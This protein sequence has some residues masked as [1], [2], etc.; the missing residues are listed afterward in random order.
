MYSKALEASLQRAVAQYLDLK[1]YLWAH[2]ANERATTPQRGY[3][4]KRAGVKPGV[5]DVLIF[6]AWRDITRD[7]NGAIVLVEQ[8]PG[9]AIELKSPSGRTSK[10][11]DHW[12][13]ELRA[14]GW[15]TA[16]CRDL[17]AVI[18][19]CDLIPRKGT[20]DAI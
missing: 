6:E 8:G 9:L 20:S 3:Q 5:P 14:R 15:K 13:R 11:Q 10:A 1:G 12:L 16:V 2:V 18:A 19:L 7:Y 4:L 17:D